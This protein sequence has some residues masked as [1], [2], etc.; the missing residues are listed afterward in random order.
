VSNFKYILTK[1][2]PPIVGDDDME[3]SFSLYCSIPVLLP[4]AY[5]IKLKVLANE[6]YHFQL[7]VCRMIRSLE[8]NINIQGRKAQ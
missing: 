4:L 7:C 6:G 5:A 2:I 3:A 1:E 8:E